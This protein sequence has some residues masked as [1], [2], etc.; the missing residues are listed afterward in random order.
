MTEAPDKPDTNQPKPSTSRTWQARFNAQ[1]F[2][3]K[4]GRGKAQ[5]IRLLDEWRWSA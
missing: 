1:G 3:E 2:W 4:V 5:P